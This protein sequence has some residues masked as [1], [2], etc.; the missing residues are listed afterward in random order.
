MTKELNLVQPFLLIHIGTGKTGTT[1]IQKFFR[2]KRDLLRQHDIHYLGMHFEWC[3]PPHLFEWQGEGKVHLFQQ[4]EDQEASSQL[5]AIMENWFENPSRSQCSIWSFEA[6][7]SRPQVYI[8]VL[9]DL[10]RKYQF[11]LRIVAY[12]RNH[13]DFMASAYKQWGVKHKTTSGPVLGFKSWAESNEG[14]LSYGRK[15]KIWDNSFGELFSIINYDACSDVVSA[16]IELMPESLGDFV[17]SQYEGR[18]YHSTPNDSLLALYALFNNIDPDPVLPDEMQFLL[19]RYPK[20]KEFH[21]PL[22]SA[23]SIF[24]ST[25]DRKSVMVKQLLHFDAAMINGMLRDRC[26]PLLSSIHDEDQDCVVDNHKMTTILLSMLLTIV[27][28]QAKE[29]EKLENSLER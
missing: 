23:E 21:P 29:I 24:E 17:R 28:E 7:Y 9:Q 11:N 1:S 22:V 6:I 10:L 18:H 13:N 8:P 16:L 25:V 5:S 3:D 19:G 14:L 27:Y 20:L 15:L 12:V 4:L 26:Q 2:S